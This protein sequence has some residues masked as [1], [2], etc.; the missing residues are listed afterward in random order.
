MT[1]SNSRKSAGRDAASAAATTLLAREPYATPKLTVYGD[2]VRFTAAVTTTNGRNDG[3]VHTGPT[4][5]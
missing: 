3:G 5:T 4:K 2:V 1:I